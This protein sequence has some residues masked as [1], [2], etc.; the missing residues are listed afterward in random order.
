[1][2]DSGKGANWFR[3]HSSAGRRNRVLSWAQIEEKWSLV[4]D[5]ARERFSA[6]SDSDLDRTRGCRGHL[7][8]QVRRMYGLDLDAAET[9]VE[10][11]R[12]N[13]KL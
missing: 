8:E 1:M 12:R 13:V 7:V 10:E 4:R 5:A 3:A 2:A 9:L 6:L 11:W